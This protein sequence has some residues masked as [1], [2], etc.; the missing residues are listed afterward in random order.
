MWPSIFGPGWVSGA[1]IAVA[2]LCF[3]LGVLG[4][5]LLV[6]GRPPRE[7]DDP[8]ERLWHRFE[9]GDITKVEFERLRRAGRTPVSPRG[10]SK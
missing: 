3:V 6:I 8:T 10:I 4:F 5:M 7:A 1:L 2:S 9:Q